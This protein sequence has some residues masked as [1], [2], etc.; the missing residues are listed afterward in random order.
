MLQSPNHS[1]VRERK[2]TNL[3]QRNFLWSF[4]CHDY[5][6][7]IH[8]GRN[9][10]FMGIEHTFGATFQLKILSFADLRFYYLVPSVLL[11]PATFTTTTPPL[12]P[13][14]CTTRFSSSDC[15]F[16]TIYLSGKRPHRAVPI[17]ITN[18]HNHPLPGDERESVEHGQGLYNN[19]ITL[20]L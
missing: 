12:P 13:R 17:K 5:I 1:C 10:L 19:K 3:Q 18:Q 11:L 6:Y 4:P 15:I 20:L 8:M 14:P 9:T 7:C 16:S 2:F